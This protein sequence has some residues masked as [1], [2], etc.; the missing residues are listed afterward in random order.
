M[1]AGNLATHHG[2]SLMGICFNVYI[3]EPMFPQNFQAY[4]YASQL[5]QQHRARSNKHIPW[6]LTILPVGFRFHPTEQ[7]LLQYLHKKVMNQPMM[8]YIPE[9]QV[10]QHNPKQLADDYPPINRGEHEWYFFSPR[11]KLYAKGN[12]TKRTVP[13]GYWNA[14]GKECSSVLFEGNEIGKWRTMIFHEGKRGDEVQ[15]WQHNPKQLAASSPKILDPIHKLSTRMGAGNLA[16]HH[17][18]SLMGIC[19]NVD[20]SEPMFPQ[21]FQAYEYASQLSQQH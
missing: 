12:V 4:E 1:C 8:F 2:N 9:V 10:W 5:S 15:V 17:E 13:G 20:I 11:E 19:F 21:N 18:N 7:E 3:S 14:S 16:T 6:N